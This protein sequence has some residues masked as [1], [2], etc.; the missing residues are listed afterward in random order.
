M[1]AAGASL[2]LPAAEEELKGDAR[3]Q[4]EVLGMIANQEEWLFVVM[5]F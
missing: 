3:G 4:H 2:L 1:P 5:F